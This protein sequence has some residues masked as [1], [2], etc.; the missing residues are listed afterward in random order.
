LGWRLIRRQPDDARPDSL[1]IRD[2]MLATVLVAVALALARLA[3]SPDGKPIGMLWL[4]M[5][6]AATT[7]SALTLLPVS[8][9][10]MQTPR[11]QRGVWFACLYAAFWMA[12]PWL[13][14]LVA[15]HRGYFPPPP[16]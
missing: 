4:I 16:L 15:W 13:I 14:A 8:P 10:L 7:I 6:L 12:L 9:F 2:L 3:P 11:F 5:F 1:S